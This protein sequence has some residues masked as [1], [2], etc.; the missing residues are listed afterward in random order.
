MTID[1]SDKTVLVTGASRGI[2]AALARALAGAGARI[3]V[4]YNRRRDEAERLVASLGGDHPIIQADLADARACV[5]LWDEAVLALGHVDV[6]VNNAGV[7]PL[8]DP[9]AELDDWLQNWD[10]TM[11][12]NLRAAE[13]LS[14]Q[15][16]AH[17]RQLPGG[18]RLIHI[19]SRAAFRGDQPEYIT[20]AASKAGMVAL[21]RSIARAYGKEGVRSFIVAPG[22]TRT[23]MAQEF[24]D[25]YGEAHV[26]KDLALERLT[27]PE[28]I[29]PIVVLLASGLADHATGTSIDINAGSYVR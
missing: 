12:V 19:A 15:A 17:F 22:F 9:G 24:I 2:G 14:R 16:V 27:E 6:L 23:E 7:A 29:A 8:M 11:R 25:V 20:Y 1:L 5:R 10:L 21:S 28:D 13:L 4:H 3:G 18:G 26:I